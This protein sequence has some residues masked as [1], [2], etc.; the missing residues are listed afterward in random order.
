MNMWNW[1]LYCYN[2]KSITLEE[3]E[4]VMQKDHEAQILWQDW[5][6]ESSEFIDFVRLF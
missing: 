5:A 1:L 3:L 6:E 4:E 2:E